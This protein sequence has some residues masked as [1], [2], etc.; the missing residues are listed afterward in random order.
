MFPFPGNLP[1]VRI[2]GDLALIGVC[3]A[4][5]TKPFVAAGEVGSKQLEK[6]ETILEALRELPVET[7]WKEIP[8]RPNFGEAIEDARK[9]DKPILL[10]VMNGH[11]CGMT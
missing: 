6:L 2:R 1:S 10:W 9:E 3:T 11:P 5:P 4:L 7:H 8:W